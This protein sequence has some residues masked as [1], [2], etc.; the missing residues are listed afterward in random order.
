ME[1]GIDAGTCAEPQ[2][3]HEF[4][5]EPDRKLKREYRHESG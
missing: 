3:S 4:N 1:S 5:T 2:P